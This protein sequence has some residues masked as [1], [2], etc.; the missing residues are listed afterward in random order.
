[1]SVAE[2]LELGAFPTRARSG[3]ALEIERV[4]ELFPPL[5]AL[6]RRR[7]G[8]LSGGEQQMVAIGRGL[9]SRPRLLMLDEPSLG[10][11][12]LVFD[13]ILETIVGLNRAGLSIVLVEQAVQDALGIAHR[14]YVLGNGRVVLSGDSATIGGS[15]HMRSAYFGAAAGGRKH[16]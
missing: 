13:R 11:A 6:L 15:S 5:K 14:A 8:S 16:D 3:R 1:M 4:L 10:L 9:V 2:N 12:P 7:A